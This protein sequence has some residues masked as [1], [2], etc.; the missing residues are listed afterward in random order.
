MRSKYYVQA[1]ANTV[2]ITWESAQPGTTLPNHYNIFESLYK[3]KNNIKV[4]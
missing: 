4:T 2:N 3:E 1:A